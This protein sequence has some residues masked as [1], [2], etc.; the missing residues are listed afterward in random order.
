[1]ALADIFNTTR[2]LLN[3][4]GLGERAA[5]LVAASDAAESISAPLITFSLS[6]GQGSKVQEGDTL[7]VVAPAAA[8]AHII[9]VTS[10]S[11]D[12]ITGV[13]GNFD[14][15]SPVITDG[16][17][18]DAVIENSPLVTSFDIHEAI[19]AIVD[20]YLWPSVYIVEQ[21]EVAAPDLIDGQEAVATDVKEI[22][23]AWQILGSTTYPISYEKHPIHVSTDIAA[24][25][26][27]LASFDWIDGST[28]YYSVK[29]KVVVAD[30]D[31]DPELTRLIATGAAALA[32]GGTF[33]EA[34]Q[35]RAKQENAEAVPLRNQA[36][37][38]LWR[39]FLTLREAYALE[40]VREHDNKITID[41]G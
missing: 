8:D 12:D 37:S 9:T 16:D 20:R 39:D 35:G 41:R 36:A 31:G 33:V 34:S 27:R 3:G 17:L 4:Q 15:G 24:S 21:R 26:G 30:D 23:G 5:L 22:I 19:T 11:T 29:T 14:I 38:I 2:R 1:M 40:L 28:G 25:T 18:D 7:S 13:D 32:L 6:S 10:K